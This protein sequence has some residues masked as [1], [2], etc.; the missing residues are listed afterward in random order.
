MCGRFVS[1]ESSASIAQYFHADS[2]LSDE[3]K[4]W[5]PRYNIA[6]TQMARVVLRH[7]PQ[8]A[9][10]VESLQ[11]GLI[12]R[13]QRKQGRPTPLINARVE[14][15]AEKPSFREAFA[16]RRCIVAMTGFYEW[17]DARTDISQRGPSQTAS[18]RPQRQPHLITPHTGQML[19][20]AGIWN[21]ASSETPATFAIL[22]TA[23]NDDMRS[24]HDRMPVLLEADGWEEWMDPE[25]TDIA[26]I[27]S[28]LGP[29]PAG[30][31]LHHPVRPEV[32]SVRAEGPQLLLSHDGSEA[33][34]S[35]CGSDGLATPHTPQ[36]FPDEFGR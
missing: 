20:V 27:G 13:W 10:K 36:L 14:T 1:I 35:G 2:D 31:L 28:L 17:T 29:V 8:S 15:A 19:A 32:N 25:I 16:H 26:Q 3:L 23:A 18:R 9:P 5:Q 11:W 4:D 30:Q 24:L 21:P 22:T 12:P 33:P 34:L 6:P 7:E